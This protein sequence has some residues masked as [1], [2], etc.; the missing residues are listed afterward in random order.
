MLQASA[1]AWTISQA[2]L[3][4]QASATG[5]AGFNIPSGVAP[6]SPVNGDMWQDGTDLKFR[7]GGVTKTVTLI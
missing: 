7:I 3:V 2:K 6:T 4:T 1:S 5:L